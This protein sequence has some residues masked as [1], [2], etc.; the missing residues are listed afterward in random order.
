MFLSHEIELTFQV[1]EAK[2]RGQNLRQI[3]SLS[4]GLEGTWSN[5]LTLRVEKVRPREE[6]ENA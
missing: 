2:S 1:I 5:S 3:M 4:E 6:K